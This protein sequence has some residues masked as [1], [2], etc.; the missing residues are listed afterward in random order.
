MA[1]LAEPGQS[2]AVLVGVSS[3]QHLEVL[4]AVANNLTDLAGELTA[5]NVWGLPA[6]NCVVVPDPKTASEMLDPLE[7][8]A[9]AA[10]D[11]LLFYF[12]GHGLAPLAGSNLYLALPGSVKERMY[13]AVPYDHVREAML[14]SRASRRVVILDCCYSGLALGQ[15]GDPTDVL[16]NEASAVGTFVLAAAAE[17]RTAQAPAWRNTAFTA[18]LLETI[19]HGIPDKGPLL[20]LNTIYRHLDQSLRAKNLPRPQA[21]DRNTGGEVALF[22]NQAYRPPVPRRA[23]P[24]DL[25]A[26]LESRYP[27]VRIGAVHELGG[28]LASGDRA[29]AMTARQRLEHIA[30]TDNPA[31]EAA[32]RAYLNGSAPPTGGASPQPNSASDVNNTTDTAVKPP[33]ESVR[34]GHH[35]AELLADAERVAR[36]I[37][38]RDDRVEVL[39]DIAEKMEA[40]DPD[41]ARRI[42]ADVGRPRR[43]GGFGPARW[44]D[45]GWKARGLSRGPDDETRASILVQMEVSKAER[46]APTDADGAERI[47]RSVTDDRGKVEALSKVATAIAATNPD[48]AAQLLADAERIAQSV[49]G[50]S[51]K[52]A[53]LVAVA[54][55]TTALE[56]RR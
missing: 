31:V 56:K 21:R 27:A 20:E 30:E 54:V 26:Q 47:A 2:R 52:A 23:L 5:E 32:A 40:I 12:A 55:A 37:P 7:F 16:A 9:Q 45:R 36:S 29:R 39:R 4:N 10:T 44:N 41:Q 14:R 43:V 38:R 25:A 1:S 51:G 11:T 34:S 19:R 3:Y 15:M 13:T 53:A 17:N 48:R 33:P 46:T 8:A 22:R 49:T 24:E 35:A 50:K 18:E 42:F 6:D 28:W